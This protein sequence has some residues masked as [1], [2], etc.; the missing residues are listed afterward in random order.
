MLGMPKC[1][2]PITLQQLKIKVVKFT[3]TQLDSKMEFLFKN[4]GISLSV[5]I[6]N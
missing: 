5:N 1:G 3:Q 4:G 2:L 6:Q